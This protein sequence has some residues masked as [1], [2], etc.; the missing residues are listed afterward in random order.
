MNIQIYHNAV[1]ITEHVIAYARNNAL[2]VGTGTIDVTIANSFTTSMNPGDTLV[3]YE[4]GT[5]VGTYRVGDVIYNTDGEYLLSGQDASKRLKDYFIDDIVN[6]NGLSTKYWMEWV[7]SQA[8]VSYNFVASGDGYI[9]SPND[10][11]GAESAFDAIVRFCQQSGWY[12]YF[13]SN[14]VCQ[15]GTLAT[16]WSNPDL[17]LLE[18]DGNML[19]ERIEKNDR[20]LRN[21]A[22]IWGGSG[23]FV[24]VDRSTPWDRGSNDK[25]TVVLGNSFIRDTGTAVDMAKKLL[26]EFSK[27][28]TIKTYEIAG[29]LD[30]AVGDTVYCKTTVFKGAA[31]VTNILVSMQNNGFTTTLT[32]DQRCPRLFGYW[33]LGTEYVY[34]GTESNG[35]YR[36][37]ID[38]STWSS[39]NTG[40]S[41]QNIRDLKIKNG[42]LV[43]S[44]DSYEIYTRNVVDS[45]WTQIMPEDT[46]VTDSGS[47]KSVSTLVSAGV[48]LSEFD[49]T[50]I[51]GFNDTSDT[52]GWILKYYPTG[53]YS[54][55]QVTTS[56][57]DLLTILDT[58]YDEV[59]VVAT[60]TI[61]GGLSEAESIYNLLGFSQQVN[62]RPS[63]VGGPVFP[64]S[65]YTPIIGTSYPSCGASL[66][67]AYSNPN[68]CYT[69]YDNK[70]YFGYFNGIIVYD[71]DDSSAVTWLFSAIAST[72]PTYIFT[73]DGDTFHFLSFYSVD[74]WY[75]WTYTRSTTST[76]MYGKILAYDA[77]A[78]TSSLA[79]AS[80][81]FYWGEWDASLV[82]HVYQ[83]NLKTQ[84]TNDTTFTSLQLGYSATSSSSFSIH[85]VDSYAIVM[86]VAN[87]FT[88]FYGRSSHVD[89]GTIIHSSFTK[90]E[91]TYTLF[92]EDTDGDVIT[93]GA[94]NISGSGGISIC[95]DPRNGIYYLRYTGSITWDVGGQDYAA[96]YGAI[97]NVP[98]NIGIVRTYEDTW[99]GTSTFIGFW[100]GAYALG[101][102]TTWP[103]GALAGVGDA[104]QS[105]GN[106]YMVARWYDAVDG[107]KTG[108]LN[109][110][111]NQA[112]DAEWLQD[113]IA[114]GKRPRSYLADS[115]DNSIAV[116]DTASSTILE[117]YNLEDGSL[118]KT[119]TGLSR[120]TDVENLFSPTGHLLQQ[121]YRTDASTPI[122]YIY[123]ISGVVF[124]PG[125]DKILAVSDGFTTISGDTFGIIGTFNTTG[126]GYIGIDISRQSPITFFGGNGSHTTGEFA[127]A[128]SSNE[129]SQLI[130]ITNNATSP[131]TTLPYYSDAR[132]S[133]IIGLQATEAGK[134]YGGTD[135]RGYVLATV[136]SGTGGSTGVYFKEVG[137]PESNWN[138]FDSFTGIVHRIETT[139]YMFSTP[140]VFVST[141]GAPSTFWQLNPGGTTFTQ[142][143]TGLPSSNIT[144]IR[145]ED[146]I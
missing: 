107:V 42:L 89:V 128:E 73:D 33:S 2:C 116:A 87:R 1:D 65:Q 93:A 127:I 120:N 23:V 24:T 77:Y 110:L 6:T 62:E 7:F 145:T 74:G 137:L 75:H 52:S 56:G 144:V 82:P 90:S 84:T 67:K 37:L 59:N 32:L 138:L 133:E 96:L 135:H 126:S 139:N 119:Y 30:V 100:Y 15:I 63:S 121:W 51:A 28:L 40:I 105:R 60:T 99:D 18:S 101:S 112:Y 141:S 117:A 109:L 71:L 25:R 64:I 69:A 14:N 29:A 44:T 115:Y 11:F 106:Y 47:T 31:I 129:G 81:Y 146:N 4:E 8:G 53:D 78:G 134:T 124:P 13:N 111:T 92:E 26:D 3:L 143:S 86:A 41:N 46:I 114:A 22:I 80:G 98:N 54:F 136:P 72:Q 83:Y 19:L 43:A 88:A 10:S 97:I 70:I 142:Y 132:Y 125:E 27:T 17:N 20:M 85:A 5:K 49:G 104:I 45:S 95:S 94:Q 66:D 16:N 108:I 68:N 38:G 61:S 35:I 103:T 9:T 58:D 50:V 12:F 118:T 130:T 79:W 36:K 131:L 39:Y 102:T 55:S 21:R 91:F 34:A 76:H 57:I 113:V 123:T 140:R 122:S 48:S